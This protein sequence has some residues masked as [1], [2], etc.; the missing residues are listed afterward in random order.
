MTGWIDT[1]SKFSQCIRSI[2]GE[3][4]DDR[5]PDD[6]KTADYWFARY[7][8][9][10]ELKCLQKDLVGDVTF[11]ARLRGM[12]DTWIRQ[13]KIPDPLSRRVRIN[14]QQAPVD[15]A[16]EFLSVLKRRLEPIVSR[17]NDQIEATK[18][19]LRVPHA[20]GW[21]LV[22]ND[23]NLVWKPDL[24]TH[25]VSRNLLQGQRTS[26][27]AVAY[28]SANRPVEVPGLPMPAFFWID[29]VLPGR[30]PPLV[31]LRRRLANA[32]MQHHAMLL[33]RPMAVFETDPDP[34]IVE[35]IVFTDIANGI[36]RFD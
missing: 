19:R 16:R 25:L 31:E 21:L 28:L 32:W 26:I 9:I 6:G 11:A 35:Q 8:T 13:G 24:F 14:L 4:L 36:Y 20:K 2:G 23:G 27:H 12:V 17:A 15:C 30:E 18:D 3:V 33:R 5:E 10:I 1:R 29:G 7:E 22:A 34:N